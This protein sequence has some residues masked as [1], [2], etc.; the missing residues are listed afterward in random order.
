[1]GNDE[2]MDL[3]LQQIQLIARDRL[4]NNKV[5]EAQSKITDSN[6]TDILNPKLNP[7]VQ[8]RTQ[9]GL[10]NPLNFNCSEC[11]KES[12]VEVKGH[13]CNDCLIKAGMGMHCILIRMEYQFMKTRYQKFSH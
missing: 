10:I 12:S 9:G 6:I 13:R 11:S 2:K 3:M 1:M 4:W 7:V 5:F 8:K